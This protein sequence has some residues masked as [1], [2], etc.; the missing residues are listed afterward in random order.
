MLKEYDPGTDVSTSSKPVAFLRRHWLLIAIVVVLLGGGALFLRR[1]KE[2]NAANTRPQFN[3]RNNAVAVS[4]ATVKKGDIVVRI[5]GLG[6]VTPL[7]TV[8]VRA[9]ISGIMQQV[10][11]K[12]GQMVKKGELLAIIDPRPYEASLEQAKATLA[13]DEALLADAQLDMK[14][15]E[16]LIKQDSVSQQQVD[17]QRATV[18]Q[19]TGNVASDRAQVKT[20]ELNLAY[21]HVASPID[22]R[23]GL[24]QID[25]GNY[26]TPGDSNGIVVVTQ[27]QPI[28]VLFTVPEDN[29]P[30][31]M[32]QMKNGGTLPVEA[33]GR[34]KQEHL[35]DGKLSTTDNVIDTTTGTLKL[36]ATFDNPD[37]LLFPGQFVNVSLLVNTL[38][39]QTVIPSGAVRRGAPD[40]VQSAFVYLVNAN[41]TVSVRPIV[42]GVVDGDNQAVTSGLALN[43]VV[44]TDGGDR[45]REGAAVELPE[46]TAAEVAKARAQAQAERKNEPSRRFRK[47]GKGGFKGPGGYGGGRPPGGG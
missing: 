28:S 15:Y 17:T 2:Q 27:L 14:R 30:D 43:D 10:N 29:I 8:T 21:T 5:P 37:L 16:D 45:L 35:A 18:G 47:G 1:A 39:D 38:K 46:T 22:G 6:T 11:F 26:V 3:F 25:P 44:V 24:R 36:R 34:T 23:I 13:R 19:D 12:E 32:S 4:V 42:L 31:I 20:A 9:Q 7:T 41:N 33:T 40:G